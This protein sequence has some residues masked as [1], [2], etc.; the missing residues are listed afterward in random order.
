MWDA[1]GASFPAAQQ[2]AARRLCATLAGYARV[3]VILQPRTFLWQGMY[4]CLRGREAAGR[5]KWQRGLEVTH[6]FG[7]LYDEALLEYRL[8]RHSMDSVEKR[9]RLERARSLHR[10]LG[11]TYDLRL[12]EIAAL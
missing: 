5:R 12:V 3:Y 7:M 2:Q 9:S 1:V 6:R 11:T 4:D 8:G 10:Q